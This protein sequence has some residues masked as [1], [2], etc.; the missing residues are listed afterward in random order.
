MSQLGV[1]S[2]I[3]SQHRVQQHIMGGS[4]GPLMGCASF[5]SLLVGLLLSHGTGERRRR[6]ARDR[7]LADRCCRAR[8]SDRL[9]SSQGLCPAPRREWR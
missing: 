6:A 7:E 1:T 8:W 5:S 2:R 9:F 4:R 3:Q